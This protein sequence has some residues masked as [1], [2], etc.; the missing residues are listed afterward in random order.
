MVQVFT[1]SDDD[2]TVVRHFVARVDALSTVDMAFQVAGRINKLVDRQGVV[3]PQGEALAALEPQDYNL[4]LKQAEASF[5]KAKSDYE[6]GLQLQNDNY[7]SQSDF[8]A[9]KTAYENAELAVENARLNVDYTVLHAPFDALITNRLVEKFSYVQPNQPVLRVQNINFLRIHVNVPEQLMRYAAEKNPAYQVFLENEDGE[10]LTDRHGEAVSLT[11][12]EN[13]TEINT[14]T[15][16]YQVTF[17]LP[18]EEGLDLLPGM[19]L[20]ARV[21]IANPTMDTGLW[22]PVSA[23]DSTGRSEFAV[24]LVDNGTVSYQPVEVGL[25]REGKA[26]ITQGISTGDK[27]VAAGVSALQE[28]MAVREFTKES[29]VL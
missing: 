24:W 29:P 23:I 7:I 14:A 19:V 27:I 17:K 13:K 8:D 22:V 5:R 20:T 9:L 26:Q 25:V 10:L 6:R 18:R 1:V 28:S 3:I 2:Q 16:T 15:Q 11:Y 4:A 12:L 21:V